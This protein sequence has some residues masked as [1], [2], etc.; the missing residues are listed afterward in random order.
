MA[1]EI[2]LKLALSQ[3][4]ID[5]D[6]ILETLTSI[7]ELAT[8]APR[9]RW[10]ANT[11]FD[12]PEHALERARMALR[13]RQS[14]EDANSTG[15]LRQTLKT[16]GESHGGLHSRGEWEWELPEGQTGLDLDGLRDLPPL[17]ALEDSAREQLL[18]ALAPSFSTDFERHAWQ[19]DV[20]ATRSDANVSDEQ[21]TVGV[22]M[23]LDL[24][25]VKASGR[26]VA[27]QEI[28]LELTGGEELAPEVREGVLWQLADSLASRLALRPA[29]ASKAKRGAALR[30]GEWHEKT[31]DTAD[32]GAL[33]SAAIDALDAHAD[34]QAKD[35]LKWHAHALAALSALAS[36]LAASQHPGHIHAVALV[37]ALESSDGDASQDWATRDFGQHSLS[38]LATLRG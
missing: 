26:E 3:P 5:R 14:G 19:I 18:S 31:L 23:A 4:V 35:D 29:D 36:R 37:E 33:L 27:I 21:V 16:S 30:D 2:E 25:A 11:Y 24:G 8:V 7:A 32:P 9:R 20:K 34:R 17:Q 10:L 15:A 1:Q 6:V 38:L 22:E 28:E 12:T 13:L